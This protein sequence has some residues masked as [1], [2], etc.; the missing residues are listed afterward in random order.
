MSAQVGTADVEQTLAHYDTAYLVTVGSDSRPHVVQIRPALESTRFLVSEPGP[1]TLRNVADHPAVTLLWPP[2]RP[3]GHTLI[4]DGT[5]TIS[6]D[7]IEIAITR[8][9]L[10]RAADRPVAHSANGCDGDCRHIPIKAD[11]AAVTPTP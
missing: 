11:P 6:G 5:A 3:T 2:R 1:H 9:I 10:H 4:V 8:A 7:L